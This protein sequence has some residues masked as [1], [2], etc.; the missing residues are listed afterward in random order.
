MKRFYLYFLAF[1]IIHFAGNPASAQNKNGHQKFDK[2]V[3]DPGHGGHDP[4]AQ[5]KNTDEKDLTLSIALLAGK[6]IK[7]KLPGVEV[8]YTRTGDYFVELHNRAAFANEQNADL[9]I[10]IHCNSSTSIKPFGTETYVMG[11]HKSEDNLEVAKTENA[12]ILLEDDY[13]EQYDG[14]DPSLDED[15]IMLNIFQSANIEQSLEFSQLLQDQMQTTAKMYDRGVHQAGF[16]ILYLTTMPGVL[17]ETGF[18]SNPGEEK[19]LMDES[20]QLKIAQAIANAVAV[21]KK[22]NE[23]NMNKILLTGSKTEEIETKEEEKIYRIEF[24]RTKSKK[25]ADNKMF[26]GMDNIWHYYEN[27]RYIYTFGKARSFDQAKDIYHK[28]VLDK[29]IKWKYLKAAEI[30]ELEGNKI[31]SKAMINDQ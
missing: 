13:Q 15:Y 23:D 24:A 10:S 6:M 4:G 20:N 26:E 28:A 7:E 14:F 9:F 11:L 29:I 21:Y 27:G 30:I 25:T 8:L 12:A 2:I 3:L 31:I 16:V 17:L 1:I 19:F 22:A 5:G 18:L